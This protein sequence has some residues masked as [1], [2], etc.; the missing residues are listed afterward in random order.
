MK[1]LASKGRFGDTKIRKVGGEIAHVTEKEAE[2]ID[3]RGAW[4]EMKT[5]LLGA[6]TINPKSGLRE[7]HKP[8]QGVHDD[9]QHSHN[10]DELEDLYEEM[11]TPGSTIHPEEFHNWWDSPES[12]NITE[13]IGGGGILGPTGDIADSITAIMEQ[14]GYDP[15]Y[16]Y[17]DDGVVNIL[18]ITSGLAEGEYSEEDYQQFSPFDESGTFDP[19]SDEFRSM[20]EGG[21]GDELVEGFGGEAGD[22]EGIIDDLDELAFLEEQRDITG[23]ILDQRLETAEDAYR[24]GIK[25][26]GT[27]TRRNLFDIGQ[28][29]SGQF[30]KGGFAGSGY[31]SSTGERAK[32]GAFQDYKLQQEELATTM[33]DARTTYD[34]GQKQMQL[35]YLKGEDAFWE[36]METDFYDRMA[37]LEEQEGDWTRLTQDDPW[38]SGV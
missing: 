15:R 18:D 16:D 6:G 27:S 8:V 14:G 37:W 33:A 34:F 22:F 21:Y 36:K 26:L 13:N 1:S 19:T 4:G 23:D 2:D 5:M 29:V 25:G 30:G 11:M 12:Y 20:I 10:T 28:Q 3:L 7:Y 17:N 35:D 32:R 38:A 31:I 9:S 24:L